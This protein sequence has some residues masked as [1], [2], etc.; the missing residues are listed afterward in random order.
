ML[1]RDPGTWIFLGKLHPVWVNSFAI[2]NLY[3]TPKQ[4]P[5]DGD[6]YFYGSIKSLLI[7]EVKSLQI[8]H[9]TKE[10]HFRENI[11]TLQTVLL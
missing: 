6:R 8:T 9:M 2:E 7:R 4:L 1:T 11:S 5:L 10:E 3:E